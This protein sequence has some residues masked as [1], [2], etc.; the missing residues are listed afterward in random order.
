[1]FSP[2]AESAFSRLHLGEFL[3]R[4]DWLKFDIEEFLISLRYASELQRR[5]AE[6]D[7]ADGLRSGE[8]F[9]RDRIQE[10][11]DDGRIFNVPAFRNMTR[12]RSL[13]DFPATTKADVRTFADRYMNSLYANELLWKKLTTGSSGPPLQIWYSSL[14]YYDLLF[15]APR[16]IL[17]RTLRHDQTDARLF[18]VSVSDNQRMPSAIFVDPTSD[19]G[20]SIQIVVDG[21]KPETLDPMLAIV[22][23]YGP[24]CIASKPSLLEVVAN[25]IAS[26]SRPV[27]LG[28]HIISSGSAMTPDLR[29]RLNAITDGR[30][31]DAYALTEFG[32]VASQCSRGELHVDTSSVFVEVLDEAGK[33]PPP[34]VV[35]E[36]VLS[37]VQNLAMPLVRYRTGDLGALARGKCQ[38]GSMSPR[39]EQL[40][41]R[42]IRCFKLPNGEL[43]PPTRFNDMF[44]CFPEMNEFQV[45]EI[46]SGVFEVAVE[47]NSG[48][49]SP[50][51]SLSRIRAHFL[52]AIPDSIVRVNSTVFTSDSKFQRY[53]SHL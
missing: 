46:A 42:I 16:K 43:F 15:L 35:G 40:S 18:C 3:Q 4:H 7:E 26:G 10:S 28:C 47:L 32:L 27:R 30:V 25:H 6:F 48:A 19:V 52:D 14:F 8:W 17:R 21:T 2:K 12:A 41:G 5:M 36:L 49:G 53:R 38:C 11:I 9:A 1:M 33:Q 29:A 22:R 39:I 20:F 45:T 50:S 13:G 34:G 24:A 44:A 23:E 31:I 37:S 51:D